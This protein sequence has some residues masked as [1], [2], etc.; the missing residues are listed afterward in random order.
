MIRLIYCNHK[1]EQSIHHWGYTRRTF[2]DLLNPNK[3]KLQ[4]KF[5]WRDIVN[6]EYPMIGCEAT[7]L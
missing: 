7:K 5:K 3:E 1:D 4:F 6:H 2:V